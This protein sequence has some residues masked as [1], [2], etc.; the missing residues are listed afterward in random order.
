MA[1]GRKMLNEVQAEEGAL[2]VDKFGCWLIIV[3]GIV[4][5]LCSIFIAL[6]WYEKLYPTLDEPEEQ[7]EQMMDAVSARIR[8]L[9]FLCSMAIISHGINEG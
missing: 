1:F 9:E 6:K 2:A 8:V 4:D 5:L 3:E 7:V